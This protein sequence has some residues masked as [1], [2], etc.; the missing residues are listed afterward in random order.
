MAQ[1]CVLLF[2]V[3]FCMVSSPC[4]L[5][6]AESIARNE[7]NYG[8]TL[9]RKQGDNILFYGIKYLFFFGEPS[10]LVRVSPFVPPPWPKLFLGHK[11][12]N[13][14]GRRHAG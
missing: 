9:E 5:P 13:N 12:T 8:E 4:G 3:L 10:A 6:S 7:D 11:A 1:R 2:R 14:L